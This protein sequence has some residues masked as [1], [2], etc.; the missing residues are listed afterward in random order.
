MLLAINLGTLLSLRL[1]NEEISEENL[2][3]T[4]V[5]PSVWSCDSLNISNIV[6]MKEA[7][8]FVK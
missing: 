4:V 8:G 1:D 5:L 6:F 7:K 2:L 3:V